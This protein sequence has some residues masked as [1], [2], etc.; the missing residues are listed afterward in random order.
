VLNW[1]VAH[2][3]ASA[4]FA[5]GLLILLCLSWLRARLDRR[6]AL[7][8]VAV[9]LLVVSPVAIWAA[10]GAP[11][12]WDVPVLRGFNF[13]GGLTLTP[14]FAA[15]L[16]GLTVYTS[17]YIAEIVRAGILSVPHGQWEASAAL[18]LQ[19]G[20]ALRLVIL[21]QAL[22]VM[23]PP[24]ASEYLNLTKNSTLAVA[25]GFQDLMSL[26]ETTL[27]QTGQSIETIAVVMV[28]FLALSLSISA[29]MNRYGATLAQRHR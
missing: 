11:F 26:G 16:A 2:T 29:A 15:L 1:Q 8:P 14:E 28:V 4:A 23:I 9:L 21:P 25:I 10:L 6:F 20:Q 7:W 18:G 12:T 3:A 13:R 19:R 22:R 17:A 24:L 5:V 27:N